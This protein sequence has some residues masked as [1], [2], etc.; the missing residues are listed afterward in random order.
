[1]K[2]GTLV[3]HHDDTKYEKAP[4][5]MVVSREYKYERWH[6]RAPGLGITQKSRYAQV[7]FS[8]CL[9][10]ECWHL[11]NLKEIETENV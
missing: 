3:W 9:Q 8:D 10:I 11:E 7:F 6:H 5:G 2:V 4:V 1:M